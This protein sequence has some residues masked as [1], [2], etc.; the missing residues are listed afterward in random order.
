MFTPGSSP[1]TPSNTAYGC[2]IALAVIVCLA[3]AMQIHLWAIDA[4][5]DVVGGAMFLAVMWLGL[6]AIV[7]TILAIVLSLKTPDRRL[8]S[9]TA[10]LVGLILAIVSSPTIALVIVFEVL[11][12][13][14]VLIL[15]LHWYRERG[16]KPR[17]RHPS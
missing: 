16:D 17:G 3:L 1:K 5:P 13:L 15:G 7:L 12:V 2:H 9:L 4:S 10:V 11:Y 8:L 14:L 6:P